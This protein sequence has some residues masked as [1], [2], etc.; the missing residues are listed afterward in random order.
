MQK[1]KRLLFAIAFIVVLAAGWISF[2]LYIQQFDSAIKV[3]PIPYEKPN[4]VDEFDNEYDVIVIGGEPEGVA[5]AVSAA[6]NGANTLLIENRAELGGL[7]T[8]GMFNIL[9][10]PRNEDGNSVSRGIFEEWHH[11]VGGSNVFGI[12]QAKAAFKK[13][14]DEEPLLTLSV[15]TDV[16]QAI[17]DENTVIGVQV[18]NEYGEFNIKG[19][20]FIDATQDGD[21]AAMSNV[22]LFLGRE[23]IGIQ[24][25]NL[26]ANLRIHLTDVNWD[27]VLETAKS[28]KFGPAELTNNEAWGF[29]QLQEDYIPVEENTHLHGLNIV[30]IDNNYYLK[31]LQIFGVN[32]LDVESK[33]EAIEKGKRET[34]N[35]LVY[36]Q[37]EFPGFEEAKIASFPTELYVRETRHIWAE[38]QLTMKDV[39]T[40]RD[41]WDSI[42]FGAYPVD[43]QALT[44]QDFSY[45]I[46][47]PKQYAI[48]FRSLVPKEIDGLLVVGRAA[49]F[50]SLASGSARV[51]PTGMVTGEAAGVAA[52]I[53]IRQDLSFRELSKNEQVIEYLR[54]LLAEQGALVDHFL[55]SYPYQGTWY[56]ESIQTLINY[57]LIFGGSTNDLR[58]DEVATRHTFLNTLK[59]SIERGNP[60][61]DEV[62]KTKLNTIY[63]NELA[64]EDGSLTLED[65]TQILNDLFVENNSSPSWQKLIEQ[66][67]ISSD[68]ASKIST[69]VHELTNKESYAI[70][71]EVFNYVKQ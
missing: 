48:P 26:S 6:R 18:K 13:L 35:I 61:L 38:Y 16:V 30:K 46:A 57:G 58:V 3:E 24:E 27:K 4:A 59:G 9:E 71:A 28:E 31:G 36:L 52:T 55:S 60:E 22:P 14:V 64:K 2:Y 29:S 63:V 45:I 10:I 21:F 42:G 41:Q 69:E 40:N 65:V 51:V 67:I 49:G 47:N 68:I 12:D 53:A 17:K 15:N 32:G 25:K 62:F 50:S 20:A 56:D 1:R 44:P 34:E 8:H 37:K 54:T 66:N 39:W 43:F 23:D 19:K 70:C 5:A 7:F 11:L 33:K